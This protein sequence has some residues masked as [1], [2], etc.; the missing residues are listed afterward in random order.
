MLIDSYATFYN[1][2]EHLAVI[3]VI[4]L[5][6]GKV[7]FKQCIPKNHKY[8]GI[9][10]YSHDMSVYLEKNGKMQHTMT[11]TYVTVMS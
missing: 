7:I 5:V 2:S 1:T 11:A 3:K 6:K 4:V 10:I 8:Y 9:K